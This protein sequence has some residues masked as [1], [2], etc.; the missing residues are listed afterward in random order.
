MQLTRK[1]RGQVAQTLGLITANLFAATGAMAQTAPAT[2]AAPVLSDSPAADVVND[3]GLVRVDA[4]VMSYKEGHGRVGATEPALN[5]TWNAG[6]NIVSLGLLY[7]TVSGATPNGAPPWSAEQNFVIY[8]SPPG[9][10]PVYP[11]FADLRKSVDVGYTRIWDTNT[12]LSV[13]AYMSDE[14][15]FTAYS[16]HAGISRDFFDKNTTVSLEVQRAQNRIDP[17]I[18]GVPTAFGGYG[19]SK[20]GPPAHNHETSAVLSVTQVMNRNWLTQISYNYGDSEGY[21]TEPY[22]VIMMINPFSGAPVFPM[23]ESRPHSR[24]RQSLYWGNKLAIGPTVL[25]FS[26]RKYHDDWGVDS[27]TADISER[28]PLNSWLYVE[29]G[30]RYYDQKAA[31]FFKDYLL[32]GQPLPAYASSDYKLGKFTAVTY[33]VKVGIKTPHNGEFYV[34]AD[35]YEQSGNGHRPNAPGILSTYNFFGGVKATKII[36]G[37]T[38]AFKAW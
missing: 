38:F 20:L 23:Y 30:L 17:A 34:Q 8:K 31:R 26:A 3:D 25:S 9:V 28:V 19:F 5:I 7:D 4:A 36:V 22:R 1:R 33:G 15:D 10:L 32:A 35:R 24:I 6:K 37:Y 13:G 2:H 27:I 21:L 12:R 29:P 11:Y 16:A 14:R 18:G